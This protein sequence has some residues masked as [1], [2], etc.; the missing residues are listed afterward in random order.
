[1]NELAKALGAP[2]S[3]LGRLR[4]YA[5]MAV[6][7]LAWLICFAPLSSAGE[8]T[9]L[10]VQL[11]G[12][13]VWFGWQGWLFPA[14]RERLLADPTSAYRRAF[15][16]DILPGV[17]FGIAQMIRPGMDALLHG[18]PRG[19]YGPACS[20]VLLLAGGLLLTSGFRKIGL[21]GAG[22]LYEY[23]PSERPLVQ[24]GV[25]S[26]VRHPL[27]LGGVIMSIGGAALGPGRSLALG[28]LNIAIL[29]L[30]TRVEDHR[31]ARVLGDSYMDYKATVGAVIPRLGCPPLWLTRAHT[32]M[33]WVLRIRP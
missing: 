32:L 12:W 20:F 23:T 5:M 30:Y 29:P 13:L 3:W 26:C 11:A 7:T 4:I 19:P 1:M 21:D 27:F 16:T 9:L 31:V 14:R 8:F 6:A 2:P 10:A 25:Y 17:S 28:A 33:Q 15:Y 22:F 24:R 18:G